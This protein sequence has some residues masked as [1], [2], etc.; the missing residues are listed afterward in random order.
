MSDGSPENSAENPPERERGRDAGR[1]SEIPARGWRDVLLRVWTRVGEDNLGLVSAGVAYYAL[2]AVFP[3]LTALVSIYGLIADPADAERTIAGLPA[4]PPEARALLKDPLKR[5]AATSGSA[6]G[7]GLLAGLLISV[8]SATRGVSSLIS[9]VNIAYGQRE[10]RNFV[11]VQALAFLFTLGAIL[12]AVGALFLAVTAA[13][14]IERLPFAVAHVAALGAIPWLLLAIAFFC[15][16]ALL[17]RYGPDRKPAKWRWVR[18]GSALATALWL[19]ASVGLSLYLA[20]FD[21][22]NRVY[23][24]VGAVVVLLLWFYL[25]SYIVV[26]GAELNAELERQTRRDT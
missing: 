18:L 26:L 8:W 14:A 1:P 3:A 4:L 16:T 23:G 25:T 2:F 24:S 5:V 7:S 15:G 12:L 17:Y 9:A 22:Y 19:A 6:L 21:S 11:V 20:R 13:V 10:R